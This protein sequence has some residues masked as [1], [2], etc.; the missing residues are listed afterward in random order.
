MKKN[1]RITALFILIIVIGLAV[2]FFRG[3]YEWSY[4][5][6]PLAGAKPEEILRYLNLGLPLLVLAV[7]AG[8][9]I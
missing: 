6:N 1:P 7:G 5:V 2:P 8:V 9:G 3:E 4:T